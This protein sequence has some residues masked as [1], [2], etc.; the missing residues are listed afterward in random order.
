[1]LSLRHPFLDFVAFELFLSWCYLN[2]MFAFPKS[3]AIISYYYSIKLLISSSVSYL[4]ISFTQILCVSQS[5]YVSM[6]CFFSIFMKFFRASPKAVIHRCS[7]KYV[8]LKISQISH[9]NTCVE[10]LFDKV[11]GLRPATWLKRDFHTIHS[12]EFCE[13]FKNTFF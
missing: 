9:E 3:E 8:F 12:C 10:S 5:T 4:H 7:S 1:M 11:A 13:I 6:Y 2:N